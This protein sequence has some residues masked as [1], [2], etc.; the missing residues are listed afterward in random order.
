MSGTAANETKNTPEKRPAGGRRRILFLVATVAV[1]AS[2][3][4]GG[5]LW[6]TSAAPAQAAAEPEARADE[7]EAGVISFEPFVVNLADRDA[8]R[9][10]R[11]SLRL[12]VGDQAAAEAGGE[13]AVRMLRVRSAILELLGEQSAAVVAT[14]EGKTALKQAIVE[15]ASAVLEPKVKVLDVLFA[16]FVVQF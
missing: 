4:V 13:D 7:H 1:V 5:Y 2:A 9:Y 8:N 6:W 14:P 10:L 15:R 11:V 12:V 3:G 16:E